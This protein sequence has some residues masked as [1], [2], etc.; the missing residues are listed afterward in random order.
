MVESPCRKNTRRERTEESERGIRYNMSNARDLA[1]EIQKMTTWDGYW[2]INA[3]T[4]L[5]DFRS[6]DCKHQR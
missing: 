1:D 4:C 3:D 6:E 5:L 2:S